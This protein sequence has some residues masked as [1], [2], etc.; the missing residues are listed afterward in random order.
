[1][2]HEVSIDFDLPDRKQPSVTITDVTV[3]VIKRDPQALTLFFTNEHV[4]EQLPGQI[5]A[6]TL[7][8]SPCDPNRIC[9]GTVHYPGSSW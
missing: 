4:L 3:P 8:V 6:G 5:E 1:M 2:A 9:G 7:G